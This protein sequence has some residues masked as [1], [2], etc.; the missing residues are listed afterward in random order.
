MA[1]FAPGYTYENGGMDNKDNFRDNQDKLWHG[2]QKF[3]FLNKKTPQWIIERHGPK[4]FKIQND[5]E[6]GA[7]IAMYI[8]YIN[9][10]NNYLLFKIFSDAPSIG[11]SDQS[12][13]I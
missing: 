13:S 3:E 9:S 5:S 11:V 6:L 12:Q 1:F 8:F 2:I 7:Q 10:L 4:G